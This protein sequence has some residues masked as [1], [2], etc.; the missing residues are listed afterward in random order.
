[1]A[2]I[3]LTSIGL[4]NPETEEYEQIRRIEAEKCLYKKLVLKE[5]KIVGSIIIG[6]RKSAKPI[7]E[8]IKQEINVEKVKNKILQEEFDLNQLLKNKQSST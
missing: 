1:V 5:G 3:D 4:V 2:G 8:I 7:A 6:E